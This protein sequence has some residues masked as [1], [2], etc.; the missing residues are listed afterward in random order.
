VNEPSSSDDSCSAIFEIKSRV[1]NSW[2]PEQDRQHSNTV[3][4]E[5]SLNSWKFG[6]AASC[7]KFIVFASPEILCGDAPYS[8][9]SNQTHFLIRIDNSV[10]EFG[11]KISY[12]LFSLTYPLRW[13]L[14]AAKLNLFLFPWLFL[15]LFPLKPSTTPFQFHFEYSEFPKIEPRSSSYDRLGRSFESQSRN[16]LK[17]ETM[18]SQWLCGSWRNLGVLR[19]WKNFEWLNRTLGNWACLSVVSMTGFKSFQ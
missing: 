13:E 12:G 15:F 19:G 11:P 10:N 1:A 6:A 3:T 17:S 18:T 8:K 2:I 9:T 5:V 4:A 14:A 7:Q 16:S